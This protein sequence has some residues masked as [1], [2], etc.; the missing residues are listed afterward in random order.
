VTSSY[1]ARIISAVLAMVEAEERGDEDVMGDHLVAAL[2]AAKALR[3]ERRSGSDDTAEF[4]LR[5]RK[6]RK[7]DLGPVKP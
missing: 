7:R 6:H 3:A 5:P 1:E 4:N 2:L